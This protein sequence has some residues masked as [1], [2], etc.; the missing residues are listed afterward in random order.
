MCPTTAPL[1]HLFY[2]YLLSSAA[3]CTISRTYISSCKTYICLNRKTCMHFSS[4]I[5]SFCPHS[6]VHSFMTQTCKFLQPIASLNHRNSSSFW[7]IV[8]FWQ[9]LYVQDLSVFKSR[10]IRV[11]SRLTTFVH[12]CLS[13]RFPFLAGTL[14]LH[15]VQPPQELSPHLAPQSSCSPPL[16]PGDPSGVP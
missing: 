2:S 5:F 10:T 14:L 9:Q 11:L 1:Y 8:W 15:T 3:S 4:R 7:T 16:L 13:L 6:S 12:Y